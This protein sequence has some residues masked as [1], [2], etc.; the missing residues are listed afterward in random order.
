M[1]SDQ[2][3]LVVEVYKAYIEDV[4]QLRT[5]RDTTNNLYQT[6]LTLFLGAQAYVGSVLLSQDQLRH[7]TSPQI[8]TWV[9][10]LVVTAIGLV[11][12]AFNRNWHRVSVDSKR[13]I[14]F[15]FKNLENMETRWPGLKTIGAQLFLDEYYDRH[16]ERRPADPSSAQQTP[17]DK[18]IAIEP[19]PRS[20]G[21]AAKAAEIQTLFRVVFLLVSFGLPAM[22]FAVALLVPAVEGLLSRTALVR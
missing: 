11:G 9:P 3:H 7:F 21:I 1:A 17:A 18:Q 4:N 13:S 12:L 10:V 14:H 19:Q 22:K 20:R 5:S 8:D 2:D 15:K 16:P 6:L